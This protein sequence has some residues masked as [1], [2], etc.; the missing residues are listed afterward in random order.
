MSAILQET[1]RGSPGPAVLQLLLSSQ[2]S[3]P[4]RQGLACESCVLFPVHGCGHRSSTPLP[5]DTKQVKGSQAPWLARPSVCLSEVREDA[6]QAEGGVQAKEGVEQVSPKFHKVS[7]ERFRKQRNK[8]PRPM[9]SFVFIKKELIQLLSKQTDAQGSCVIVKCQDTVTFLE[10][11]Y[12][13][14][15]P[16]RCG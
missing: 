14:V 4:I 11:N 15:S 7:F 8:T 2:N 12:F 6:Q 9:E 13:R 5:W 1:N 16:K 3:S 10:K